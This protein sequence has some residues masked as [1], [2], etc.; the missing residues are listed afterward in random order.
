VA[1]RKQLR[2]VWLTNVDDAIT[3]ALQKT[4]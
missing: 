1:S 3:G 2:F 4:S